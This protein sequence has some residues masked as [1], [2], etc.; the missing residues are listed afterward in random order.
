MRLIPVD[1]P[2]EPAPVPWGWH[3]V[4]GLDTGLTVH[5]LASPD[6][7]PVVKRVEISGD[8][9][10][11]EHLREIPLGAIERQLRFG[12]G[13]EATY[14]YDEDGEPYLVGGGSYAPLTRRAE[15]E[16]AAAFAKRVAHAYRHYTRQSGKPA[17]AMAEASGLPVG[18][19]RR[20]I[21]EARELGE[22][23]P[24]TRGRAG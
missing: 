13:A 24:G 10:H 3:R 6:K 7:P 23:E 20:W 21:R 1:K 16:D 11:A 14:L 9:V 22:L 18:T 2:D 17:V 15:G 8:A 12:V 19:I 4:E 5:I